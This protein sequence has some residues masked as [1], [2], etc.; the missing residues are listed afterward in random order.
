MRKGTTHVYYHLSQISAIYIQCIISGFDRAM[1]TLW[2][3]KDFMNNLNTC[4]FVCSFQT[5][6]CPLLHSILATRAGNMEMFH[7]EGGVEVGE[8]DEKAQK[9][10]VDIEDQLT[11]EQA[12]VLVVNAPSSKQQ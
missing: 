11:E 10:E 3:F 8:V 12:R 2:T 7:H 5:V 4:I 9:V 6:L 1:I